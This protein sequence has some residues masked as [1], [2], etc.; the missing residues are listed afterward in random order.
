MHTYITYTYV[1][2]VT[3]HIQSTVELALSVHFEG[4]AKSVSIIGVTIRVGLCT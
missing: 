4:D 3:Y 1:H 2:T